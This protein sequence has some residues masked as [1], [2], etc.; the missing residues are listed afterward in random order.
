M[1]AVEERILG[2]PSPDMIGCLAPYASSPVSQYAV[3]GCAVFGF[4]R[5]L[6]EI[7]GIE[8]EILAADFDVECVGVGRRPRSLLC[9]PVPVEARFHVGPLDRKDAPMSA[10]KLRGAADGSSGRVRRDD[11]RLTSQIRLEPQ[12]ASPQPRFPALFSG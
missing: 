1:D 10:Q 7:F 4:I 12:L 2:A 8:R 5:K 6:P 11:E 3:A 9:I